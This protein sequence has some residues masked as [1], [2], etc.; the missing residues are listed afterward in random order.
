MCSEV[1]GGEVLVV[2]A[3]CM[4]RSPTNNTQSVRYSIR[5]TG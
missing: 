2:T 5:A 3:C 1:H 4:I